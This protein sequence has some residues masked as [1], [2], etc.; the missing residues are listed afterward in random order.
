MDDTHKTVFRK[1]F[2][3]IGELRSICPSAT[4]LVS[5]VRSLEGTEFEINRHKRNNVTMSPNRQNIKLRFSKVSNKVE[6]AMTWLID[7]LNDL[8]QN[9]PM[10]I[11]YCNS[12]ADASKIYTYITSRMFRR[13][14][15]SDYHRIERHKQ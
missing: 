4:L 1:W 5:S 8:K 15:Y 2:S 6:I 12:I 13:R 7:A 10:T 3:Y 9:F 14:E 11:I